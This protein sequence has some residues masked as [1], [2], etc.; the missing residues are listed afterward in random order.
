M[1]GILCLVWSMHSIHVIIYYKNRTSKTIRKN[2]IK[3][4]C[5]Q[6]PNDLRH[7]HIIQSKTES[8]NVGEDVS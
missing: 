6:V 5:F 8:T 3:K 4:K 7:H 1:L 2:Q